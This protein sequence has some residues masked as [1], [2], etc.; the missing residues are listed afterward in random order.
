VELVN[1]EECEVTVK[2]GTDDCLALAEG[3]RRATQHSGP[4]E[5]TL[6]LLWE[7]TA[8][9]LQAASVASCVYSEHE[10][11]FRRVTTFATYRRH[12]EELMPERERPQPGAPP[13]A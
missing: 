9:M 4:G 11:E 10:P 12:M 8:A 7:T 5:Q 13:A 3:L 1:I 6:D 2:L